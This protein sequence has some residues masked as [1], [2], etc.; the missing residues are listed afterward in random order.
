MDLK[1]LKKHRE[2]IFL[3]ARENF[4]LDCVQIFDYFL[5][6]GFTSKGGL[7]DNS[8]YLSSLWGGGSNQKPID[9]CDGLNL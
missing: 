7:Q 3:D 5:A 1:L 4:I 8:G 2:Q 6:Y 9:I